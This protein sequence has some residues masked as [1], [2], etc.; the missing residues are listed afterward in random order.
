MSCP[1]DAARQITTAARAA[2]N[3]IK[4]GMAWNASN[5]NTEFSKETHRETSDTHITRRNILAVGIG[6]IHKPQLV[7]E[8]RHGRAGYDDSEIVKEQ[9]FGPRGSPARS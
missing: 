1:A 7:E 4:R 5:V 6:G 8:Q 9:H 3:P 2:V